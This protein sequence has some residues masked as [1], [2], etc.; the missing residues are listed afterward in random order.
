MPSELPS[1]AGVAG[2]AAPRAL[3]ACMSSWRTAYRVVRDA[4]HPA[5]PLG[6]EPAAKLALG[7]LQ[8]AA[9]V[10]L[11]RVTPHGHRQGDRKCDRGLELACCRAGLAAWVAPGR[12]DALVQQLSYLSG[13]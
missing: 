1:C 3:A 12:C 11:G 10:R 9:L 4:C 6:I 2:A 13:L 7:A 5:R 8:R